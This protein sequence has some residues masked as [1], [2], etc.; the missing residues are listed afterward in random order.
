MSPADFLE[1]AIRAC[2]VLLTISMILVIIRILRGPT[3]CNRV[4]AFDLLNT[5]MICA[6]GVYIVN[7][8]Q[9]ILLYVAVLASLI[10]FLGTVAYAYYVEREKK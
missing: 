2:F 7:T 8:D 5:L 3:L 10:T 4:V 1:L 9:A 6:M